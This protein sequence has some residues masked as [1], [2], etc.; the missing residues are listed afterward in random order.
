MKSKTKKPFH[1][2]EDRVFSELG[3]NALFYF[4][5]IVALRA[6]SF[7]LIPIYTYSLDMGDYGRLALLLQT[8]QILVIVIGLGSRTALVRFA[9]E[10]E[11]KNQM[12]LLL[13]TSIFINV[14]AAVLVT[15]TTTV[16]L[17]PVFGRLLHTDNTP[18]Y[19]FW[20]CA[21]A[22][23]NCLSVHLVTYYRAG[24]QGLKVTLANLSTAASLILLTMLFLRFWHLGVY[25]ALLAQTIIYGLLTTFLFVT[26][27]SKIRMSISLRLTW[28]LIRFGLPLIFVMAGGLITQASGMYFMSYFRG[29]DEVSIYSLGTKMA[30]I[31]EMSLILPFVMAYEPFVYSRTGK[32]RVWA[33]ISRLLTYLMVAFAFVAWAIVFVA[34]D[35]LTVIAPPEYGS[36]YFLIFLLLPALAFRGVYYIGESLLYL[37]KKTQL[38]GGVVTLFTVVSVGL[39]YALIGYWGMYGALAAYA[40]TTIGTGITVLKLGL[41]MSPVRIEK[42][43]LCLA[44]GLLFAFLVAVYA[45]RDA[46]HYVYYIAV[47]LSVCVGTLFLCSSSFVKEDERRAVH[48]FFGRARVLRSVFTAWS[49]RNRT[50][51]SSRDAGSSLHS[52]NNH[53]PERRFKM[54]NLSYALITAA[55]NEESYIRRT[56]ASV[57]NQTQLPKVWIIVS[58]GSTDR[59]D[60]FVMEFARDREFIRFIRLEN[61]GDRAF[62]GQAFAS[63]AGYEAIKETEFEFVGFL[64]ADITFDSDYYEK[65]LAMFLANPQ[66][67]VAGGEILEHRSGL[68][69]PRFGNSKDN[70]AGAIQFFRRRCYEDIGSH[71]VPL[72]FGGHDLVANIM[73]RMKGWEVRT[74]S[75][76]PVVHHRPTGSAAT[77]LWRALFRR[78]KEDYTIGYSALFEIAKCIRRMRERPFVIASA[79]ALCGYIVA[80]L[81]CQRSVL[82]DEFLRYLRQEQVS[83][84]LGALRGPK[85]GIPTPERISYD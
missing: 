20:T 19:V 25:G 72:Q 50:V 43:R 26:V 61:Q 48:T 11:D 30:Q 2:E 6:S 35:L 12:G 71:L 56:L 78:G 32:S 36:A 69:G 3:K 44:G 51:E 59:T 60:E 8:G 70:V 9:K 68:L 1:A 77:T 80:W 52:H 16:F 74:F 4:I 28:D 27:S 41:G 62:S 46:S 33:D 79:L 66:L 40:I 45:L 17:S 82:P 39:N 76:L 38:V 85:R 15:V 14:A 31:A 29:L 22:A 5:G 65:L 54:S 84:I 37:E 13:G 18:H 23:F 10:Y 64:D 7:L 55:K 83:R 24:E 63:N 58:D 42:E 75:D 67:G 34:R 47:P 53:D 57:V 81:T 73:A 21:A 49:G